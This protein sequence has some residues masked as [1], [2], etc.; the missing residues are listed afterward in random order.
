MNPIDLTRRL[1]AMKTINPPGQERACAQFIGG[2]LENAGFKTRYQEFA[3]ART[4]LI[5]WTDVHART[6]ERDERRPVCFS[7]HLIQYLS[8]YCR[9]AVTR[10]PAVLKATNYT[11]LA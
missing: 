6:G 2:L 7:G 5:A 9:G 11:A 1:V 3:E 10:S 4:C 8:A